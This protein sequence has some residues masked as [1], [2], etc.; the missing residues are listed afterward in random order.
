MTRD[1]EFL[2][3][4]GA[5]RFVQR[6]WKQFLN[7]DFENLAEHSMR[8]AWIA[9]VIAKREGVKDEEKILKMAMIHDIGES[10]TLDVNYL[11]RLYATRDEDKAMKDILKD[12]S[13]ENEFYDLFKEYEERKTL[14]AK[15]VKDADNLDVDLELAEQEVRGIKIRSLWLKNRKV[16]YNKLYTKTAK[17]LWKQI[18]DSN[19]HDWHMK[20]PNR[21][22]QGDWKE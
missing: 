15:I 8:V 21:F 11:T 22:T 17:K 14:E 4:I 12:T 20:A 10:R 5:I 7:A 18:Q 6:T 19:P 1:L 9:L 16:I 13:L 2:Y 3:E